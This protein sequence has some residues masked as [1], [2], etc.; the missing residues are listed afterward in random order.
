M[1]DRIKFFSRTDLSG[2]SYLKK[3]EPI[4]FG[5][6]KSKKYDIND[7]IELYQIKLYIDSDLFLPKWNEKDIEQ[8]RNNMNDIS[9]TIINFWKTINNENI[10]NLF[11]DVVREFQD[12][13]WELIEK[14]ETYKKISSN[15]FVF[16]IS[17]Y[18]K[19]IEDVLQ[20][21]NLVKY[22]SSDIRNYLLNYD[23]SAELLL[24]QYEEK[25]TTEYKNI[26][27]PKCLTI[28]DKEDIFSKYLDDENANLNYIRLLLHSKDSQNIKLSPH[29]RL[30]AK[31]VEKKKNDEILT[32]GVGWESGI[33]ISFSKTQKEPKKISHKDNILNASYSSQ[34]IEENKDFISLFHNF[35]ELFE[36]TDKEDRINLINKECDLDV[37]E[38]TMIQSSNEYRRGSSFMSKE[39]LSFLQISLYSEFLK[40]NNINIETILSQIVTKYFNENFGIND[41]KITFPS[42]NSS[43][44]EKVR[45]IA[46]EFESILKQYK[47]YATENEIDHELLQI[48]SQPCLINE[49]P[50]L[51]SKKYIYGNGEEIKLLQHY[52]FSDQSHLYYIETHKKE[53]NYFAALIMNENV[54][55]EDFKNYQ[56]E[57]IEYLISEKHLKIDSKGFVKISNIIFISIIGDLY[58]N[59]VVSYWHYPL[60]TRTIIDEMETT[61]LIYFGNTL[62]SEQ[63]QKYFNYYLNKQVFTNGL[64]LRNSFLHGTN[65]NSE[66]KHKYAYFCYLK[67]LVL[68]LLKIE[69]DLLMNS[70]SDNVFFKTLGYFALKKYLTNLKSTT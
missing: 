19:R 2:S 49:I 21:K 43:Y 67:L 12:S 6:D 27:F 44:L 41:Y 13:F 50:S 46:P 31:K 38:K 4:L 40:K 29:T 35:S 47:L 62:F 48:S 64:D 16:V 37:F 59:E 51:L 22:Y 1:K 11:K 7:I 10:I 20:N 17:A 42:E 26:Y 52:F 24:R 39:D 3:A 8:I 55:L 30:K 34:W 63:E 28:K 14:Y 9:N 65:E 18:N 32:N 25:H 36:Y 70:L 15:N 45:M 69:N 56:R 61:G 53:Y 60:V 58:F 23:R 33:Q 5:F 68:V 54:K 66:E 57:T